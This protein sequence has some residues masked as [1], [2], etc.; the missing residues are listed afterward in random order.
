M[1]QVF[2]SYD[3]EDA[4]KARAI[5]QGLERA[6]HFVWWDLHIKGGA[7]YG[8]EIEQALAKS[9]VVVVLWSER[10]IASAWVRDEAAA[11]RDGGRLIPVLIESVSPPMGFR[12]YQNVD[13]SAWKGRNSPP[14][15]AELLDSIGAVTGSGVE[16][17]T[18]APVKLESQPSRTAVPRW[19]IGGGAALVILLGLGWALRDQLVRNYHD[20]Q[21]VAVTAADRAAEP[22]ARDLLVNL[23][24]LQSARSGS[25]RL[26]SGSN[27]GNL[28][29]D[30]VFESSSDNDASLTGAS[31]VLLNGEDHSILWS[32]D[33]EQPSG[34]LSDLKQQIAFTAAQVLECALE[35]LNADRP[36]KPATLKD[37]L[38]TCSITSEQ[39]GAD[40][41]SVIAILQRVIAEAPKFEP[42]WGSL[43]LAQAEMTDFTLAGTKENPGEKQELRRLIAKAR[44]LNPD[45][46]Q[47]TLA[48]IS[49]LPISKYEQA[50][51]LS[52]KANSQ[53]PDNPVV[54][55]TRSEL[56]RRVGRMRESIEDARKAATIDPLSSNLRNSYISSLFYAGR[57][58]AA[59][60]ELTK[61]EQLWPGTDTLTDVRYRF[62]LRYGDPKEALRI[63]QS[64]GLERGM[65]LFLNARIDPS[66]ANLAI[67]RSFFEKRVHERAA[68]GLSYALQTGGQ[69]GWEDDLY[70]LLLDWPQAEELAEVA[71]IYFRPTLAKFRSDPRFMRV[72]ERAGLLDYWRKSGKWPDF[73]LDPDLTYDC[74][75]EAAKLA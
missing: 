73:C 63:V 10:S 1:A 14:R 13:F 55:N 56:L 26:I 41:G 3:R 53:S 68:T 62:H 71:D 27:N 67:L 47:A 11:G 46:A 12:Q 45:M 38:T 61:I 59:R 64:E 31:L 9:D 51:A 52:D 34:K 60:Q 15:M 39:A 35:G 69:F 65:E 22:L 66:P 40:P 28:K 25:V 54:L 19:L 23:G 18:R 2:L 72:A 57:F 4:P 21:T 43:L 50:L 44:Q 17:S 16:E 70:K 7:E 6:G 32:K 36:L 33:F 42:A 30:L 75:A 58:E 48:E 24:R 49:L 20:M 8:R 5:A 74:K 37:Y 29:P